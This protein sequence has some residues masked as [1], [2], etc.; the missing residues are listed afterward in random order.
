[1]SGSLIGS[2]APVG[3]AQAPASST[4]TTT[5]QNP[6]RQERAEDLWQ[7]HQL[8]VIL[9][10]L[11]LGGYLGVL[12]LRPLVLLKL[13]AKDLEVPWTTWRIPLGMVRWFKYRDRVLDAWVK[14]HWS[15]AETE[16]LKLVTSLY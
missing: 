4:P 13:P 1:V 9:A 14:Q 16:F 8:S 10:G 5:S 11:L 7:T 6:T 2:A 12:W 3:L 15:V